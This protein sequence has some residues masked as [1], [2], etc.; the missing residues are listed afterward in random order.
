MKRICCIFGTRPE[1]IKIA[2]VV[3]A[4]RKRPDVGCKVCVTAQHR[5]MLDQVLGAFGIVPDDDFNIMKPNQSLGELTARL[6]GKL[7]TYL[8]T[9][10][11][12]VVL[13]QGDTTTVLAGALA[14]FYHK[15]AIGHVEAGLRTGNLYSPWPEEANRVLTTRLARWHFAPSEESKTHKSAT[16]RKGLILLGAA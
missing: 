12:D 15:I 1:A 3:R 5:E 7:D 9:E 6:V 16:L 11:P 8:A 2:P 13:V 4:L 14:A 10:K